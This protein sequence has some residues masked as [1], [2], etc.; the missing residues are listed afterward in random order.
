MPVAY[1]A[2]GTSTDTNTAAN[3]VDAA[4]GTHASN[5]FQRGGVDA[6]PN[7][8][9]DVIIQATSNSNVD[10]NP[11]QNAA[12][13]FNSI[14]LESGSQWTAD[15]TNHLTLD[16]ESSN[17][18]AFR[19]ISATYVHSN[20]TIVINNGGSM[21]HAA[22][23]GGVATSTN[24]IYD[25][26]ISGGGTTCEIFGDTT[27]HRNME[28]G[29]STTVLRGALTVNG[30]LTVN[31]A[32]NTQYSSTDRNLTVAGLCKIY[33]T[34]TGNSSTIAV[35]A[36]H[37]DGGTYSAPDSSGSTTINDESGNQAFDNDG[38]FTHNGGTVTINTAG[39]SQID[40]IGTGS[41][42]LN[43]LTY[44][45]GAILEWTV[46][47]GTIDGNLSITNGTLQSSNGNK[48]LTVTGN[49]TVGDGSGSA[50]TAVLGNASEEAAQ[51]FGSLTI[52]SDGKYNATSGTTTILGSSGGFALLDEGA[53]NHNSGT[54]KIDFETSD[55]NSSTRIHQN[56]AKKLNSVEIEM[57]RTTDEVTWSV[58]SG[59]SQGIAG[60]LTLTKGESYLYS[61][62]HD[63][64]VD[65]HFLVDANGTWGSL[66]HSGAH[67]AKSLT[68]NNGGTFIAT[69]GTTKITGANINN[70]ALEGAG[71]FTH[72]NGT[73][74]FSNAGYRMPKSG[75]FNNVTVNGISST[76]GIHC[77]SY[78]M[79]PHGVMP[80]G[81][82]D[83][84]TISIL[85]KLHIKN[86]DFRPYQVGDIFIHDLEIGDGTGSAET[87]MFAMNTDDTFDGKVVVDNVTIHSDGKLRFGD[88]D[89]TST[90]VGSSA[91]EV[92]GAFRNIGG[93]IDIV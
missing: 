22:I 54:V 60:N 57:N 55:L 65:G 7:N 14:L 5:P 73:L 11:T 77:M 70:H 76:G 93:A 1:W 81:T 9:D 62:A 71:T 88:G 19:I 48:A 63:F 44:S 42:N 59:T 80:D 12:H 51:M 41:G 64:D 30:N 72:N 37:L 86:D 31:G 90:T 3:W 85:G 46:N 35:G 61:L 10:R 49:V 91:M 23:Q 92:R 20:G 6:V 40:W 33:G 52:A 56:G 21:S 8:L 26:T 84:E 75:T 83:N 36:L 50:N 16:G 58:A 13:T 78:S 45:G 17:H 89:E 68:I 47:G 53:F 43:N 39:N 28:A 29:G 2:G 82:S 38:T 25:L 74:E 18:F 24:G 32:L 27:I 66:G 69:S 4:N 67:E 15:G 34:L 87:A 79:L